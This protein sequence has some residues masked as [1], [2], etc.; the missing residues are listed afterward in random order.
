M[1]VIIGLPDGTGG[2]RRPANQ[3]APPTGLDVERLRQHFDLARSG[4]I[5]TNNAAS[6]Q[7]PR[8]LLDLYRS[9]IPQY[10]NVHRGQSSASM[11]TTE[12]FEASYDTIA[13]W[14]NAPSRR[15]IATY[16]NTTEAHNA[17]MYSL[18]TEF[19]DGDNI[20]TTM[21]EHNSNFVPWYALCREILPQFGRQVECRVA[22]FDRDT[23]ELDLGHLASLVDD[24]TKLVCCTGAS[25]FLGTK[26]P[27]RIVRDIANASGYP[28]P[29]GERRSRLLVDGA[30]LVPS[31]PVDVR[32]MDVDYLSFSFHKFMA[33]FGV[34]VLY[35]KE[36][37]LAGSRPFL[38]GG[39]MIA[40]RGVWVDH[41]EYNE[42]PWKFSAGT[43]NILGV[44]AS[45]QAL[46]LAVDLVGAAGPATY[47][48]NNE[49]VPAA[50]VAATMSAI[51]AHTQQLTQR[52]IDLLRAIPGLTIHG[53]ADA[54]HRSPLVA[55]TVDGWDP[56]ALAE[57]LNRV[58]VESR[59]G[60]HC[61]GLA[62]RDL[63][64]TASCRLSFYLYNTLADAERAVRAVRVL[65]TGTIG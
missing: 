44:I 5:V 65:V 48:Q 14:L 39:D 32:E 56:V 57:G 33:P 18:M 47:F 20:V 49:P 53:P 62:H 50:A 38:Y 11:R 4:R 29:N 40:D 55:F 17:V 13:G 26:P 61:A 58:G 12:L 43:P 34:G 51:G 24:R 31:S 15:C 23:G 37:L 7:P 42:L 64:I 19:R 8:Q 25:N 54:R 22:R 46:R 30:Q 3:P 41:V 9:L 27:I 59:A 45:A 16:R 21:M 60:C 2:Q 10:E 36:H 28:Q 52:A 63:G 1:T 35:A 6:T